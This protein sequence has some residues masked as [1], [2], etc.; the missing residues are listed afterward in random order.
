M[1]IERSLVFLNHGVMAV[2][3]HGPVIV[4][5]RKGKDFPIQLFLALHRPEKFDK[6]SDGDGHAV[7]VLTIG[8][9]ESGSTALHLASEEGEVHPSRSHKVGN[10]IGPRLT[11]ERFELVQLFLSECGS[12]ESHGKVRLWTSCMQREREYAVPA[13]IS[14]FVEMIEVGG[15]VS[16]QCLGGRSNQQT[17]IS[18]DHDFISVLYFP[19]SFLE[20]VI[21][22]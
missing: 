9:V 14:C 22:K 10:N 5:D 3:S 18:N 12:P 13:F 17:D 11:H 19:A 1:A 7:R 8:N 2:D 20:Q 21:T 16:R 15:A 4:R 6:S